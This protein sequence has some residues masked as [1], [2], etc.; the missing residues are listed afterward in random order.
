M[1]NLIAGGFVPKF[2]LSPSGT[3][4][5]GSMRKVFAVIGDKFEFNIC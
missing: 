5:R 3:P 1:G 4:F 2:E